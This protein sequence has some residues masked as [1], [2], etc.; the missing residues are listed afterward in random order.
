M[1]K[2]CSR[3]GSTS[4]TSRSPAK[5]SSNSCRRLSVTSSHWPKLNTPCTGSASAEPNCA[6]LLLFHLEAT[7]Q[8]T[9]PDTGAAE[10]ESRFSARRRGRIVV[11]PNGNEVED[12]CRHPHQAPGDH[13]GAV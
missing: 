4:R 9:F 7:T 5:D 10:R 2:R 12:G 6:R 8:G 13:R 1:P 11:S 3:Q